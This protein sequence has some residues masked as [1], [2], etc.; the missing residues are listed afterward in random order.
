VA[1]PHEHSCGI[2]IPVALALS[3]NLASMAL[4]NLMQEKKEHQHLE[5][6]LSA[7]RAV[8]STIQLKECFQAAL[9][10]SLA[11]TRK[12]R[13]K[14]LGRNHDGRTRW[15]RRAQVK[16][17]WKRSPL[18]SVS[19]KALVMIVLAGKRDSPKFY[20]QQKD[21]LDSG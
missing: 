21:N 13:A 4:E 10:Q 12:E 20:H 16:R 8:Q 18:E 19:E 17:S 14:K 11:R 15:S 6:K 2:R 9:E 1:W 5:E 7:S 3:D